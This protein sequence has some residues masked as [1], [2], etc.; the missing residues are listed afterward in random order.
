MTDGGNGYEAFF[1]PMTAFP[2]LCLQLMPNQPPVSYPPAAVVYNPPG[3][4]RPP[5][6]IVAGMPLTPGLPYL[7][8]DKVV[9]NM[10]CM[11]NNSQ[12]F[13]L[14]TTG[15]GQTP[16]EQYNFYHPASVLDMAPIPDGSQVRP[17]KHVG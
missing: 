12:S 8:Q 13:A 1:N 9:A 2:N 14:C 5:P 3:I 10:N 7:I 11:T 4:L 6:A 15:T 17:R 16:P